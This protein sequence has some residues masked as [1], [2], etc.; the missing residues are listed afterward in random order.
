M[1]LC[2][3]SLEQLKHLQLSSF[4]PRTTS[5]CSST[6]SSS[7]STSPTTSS[8]ISSNLAFAF[9]RLG[10]VDWLPEEKFVYH[11]SVKIGI[12]QSS[13]WSIWSPC[14]NNT[15]V[16]SIEKMLENDND[17]SL[18]GKRKTI[19]QNAFA[20]L[21]VCLCFSLCVCSLFVFVCLFVCVSLFLFVCSLPGS[22]SS[23]VP[24]PP[25]STSSSPSLADEH[26]SK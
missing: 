15:A 19:K 7:T 8:T 26:L 4:S 6:S 9:S 10:Q 18:D 21:C 17:V 2:Q 22:S 3:K 23:S 20:S 25:S 13:Q 12:W 14:S 1:C 16:C 5:W 11:K 24:P